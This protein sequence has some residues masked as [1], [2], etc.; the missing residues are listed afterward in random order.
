MSKLKFKQLTVCDDVQ[1]HYYYYMNNI[2]YNP[3]DCCNLNT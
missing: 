3:H 2:N 1:T